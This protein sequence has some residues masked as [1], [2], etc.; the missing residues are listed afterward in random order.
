MQE[1]LKKIDFYKDYYDKSFALSREQLENLKDYY[2]VSL[3]YSSNAIEGNTLTLLK[4]AKKTPSI[5][6]KPLRRG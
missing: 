5:A 4:I 3:T 6:A 1:L 2:R